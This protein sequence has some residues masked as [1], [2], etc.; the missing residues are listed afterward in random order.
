MYLNSIILDLKYNQWYT[1]E[2]Y[3]NIFEAD[4]VYKVDL[5]EKNA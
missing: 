1:E 5:K 2:I 4:A 3:R